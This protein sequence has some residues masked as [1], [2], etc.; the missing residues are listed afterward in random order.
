MRN[1]LKMMAFNIVG[2]CNHHLTE[3]EQ[4]LIE[5]DSCSADEARDMLNDAR[6]RVREGDDPE[7]VLYE[8]FRLEPDY[9][10]DLI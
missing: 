10:F 2:G 9:A 6:G 3:I 4:I 1:D 8:E 5:R 7:E